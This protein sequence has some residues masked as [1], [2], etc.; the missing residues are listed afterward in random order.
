MVSHSTPAIFPTAQPFPDAC[1]P[2]WFHLNDD[3]CLVKCS[4]WE[5]A[6][7]KRGCFGKS[8][9]PS[10]MAVFWKWVFMNQI[11]VRILLTVEDWCSVA[12][13]VVNSKM[14]RVLR[15]ISSTFDDDSSVFWNW[16]FMNQIKVR[17]SLKSWGLGLRIWIQL[18]SIG[19]R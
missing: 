16:V 11:K 15:K 17:I 18:K 12:F 10:T 14:K 1:C 6:F 2:C 5:R 4:V 19:W 3:R 7:K 9:L 8:H 13:E